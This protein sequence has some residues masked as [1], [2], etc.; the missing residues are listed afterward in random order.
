[1]VRSSTAYLLVTATLWL[2]VGTP[3][4]AQP[5]VTNQAAAAEHNVGLKA[6]IAR[7]DFLAQE[8]AG[9]VDVKALNE[10]DRKPPKGHGLTGKQK[11]LIVLAAVGFVALIF[12]VIKNYR[13]CIKSDPSGCTPGVDDP[14]TCLEYAPKK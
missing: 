8:R 1:M 14:C 10:I 2:F 7:E 13:E 6:S 11:T 12:F 5:A 9:T 3:V 4:S